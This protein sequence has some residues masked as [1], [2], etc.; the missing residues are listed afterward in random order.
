MICFGVRGTIGYDY[1]VY[2]FSLQYFILFG[3]IS[4]ISAIITLSPNVPAAHKTNYCSA[5]A[6][7]NKSDFELK[8]AYS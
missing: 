8:K 6:P 1:S 4:G 2:N 7:I 3:L 5:V